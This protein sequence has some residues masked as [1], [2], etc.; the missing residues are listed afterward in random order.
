MSTPRTKVNTLITNMSTPR[1]NM[2]TP[3]TNMSTPRGH[4]TLLSGSSYT[5]PGVILYC[6]GGPSILLW[7]YT[8]GSEG[9]KSE[10]LKAH[11]FLLGYQNDA[12]D[13]SKRPQRKNEWSGQ[14]RT[15][16]SEFQLSELQKKVVSTFKYKKNSFY[17]LSGLFIY[18]QNSTSN[19]QNKV[20][21][22]P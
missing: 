21:Q 9:F 3:R 13:Q 22:P 2:N 18:P 17:I 20:I 8:T 11:S 15:P 7:G 1:T 10:T 19:P 12:Y 14:A 6:S 4:P 5:A 16:A